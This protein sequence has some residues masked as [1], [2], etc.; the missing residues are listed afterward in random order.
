LT[1]GYINS[2]ADGDSRSFAG[3]SSLKREV[4]LEDGGR[5]GM[6]LPAAGNSLPPAIT[7][8][9]G[10]G[11]GSVGG[12]YPPGR[13]QLFSRHNCLK[14]ESLVV[15]IP[16]GSRSVVDD[17]SGETHATVAAFLAANH[18]APHLT[19]RYIDGPHKGK[20]PL[21]ARMAERALWEERHRKPSHGTYDPGRIQVFTRSGYPRS[22]NLFAVITECGDIVQEGGGGAGIVFTSKRDFYKACSVPDNYLMMYTG[23]ALRGMCARHKR[24]AE[25]AGLGLGQAGAAPAVKRMTMRAGGPAGCNP[26]P[27]AEP[28]GATGVT[29]GAAAAAGGQTHTAGGAGSS[30]PPYPPSTPMQHPFELKGLAEGECGGLLEPPG[31]IPS[32]WPEHAISSTPSSPDPNSEELDTFLGADLDLGLELGFDFDTMASG[33]TSWVPSEHSSRASWLGSDGTAPP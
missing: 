15:H 31:S 29:T 17:T 26:E 3:A 33:S 23:G 18:V 7:A 32:L 5:D 4:P 10:S 19:L 24:E 11:S 30:A 20:T 1:S 14:H 9:E 16:A 13:L 12:A 8:V 21:K 27:K 25:A 6:S 28:V 22:P 2:A